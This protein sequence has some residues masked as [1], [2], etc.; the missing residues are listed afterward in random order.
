M[1]RKVTAG[2][3]TKLSH[4]KVTMADQCKAMS[5]PES[6]A[7]AVAMLKQVMNKTIGE[8][9]HCDDSD[10]CHSTFLQAGSHENGSARNTGAPS[11]LH[12]RKEC[13]P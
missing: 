10:Q 5:P 8:A 12:T 4:L 11:I 2:G 6:V 7:E 13:A 9:N 3:I 1:G